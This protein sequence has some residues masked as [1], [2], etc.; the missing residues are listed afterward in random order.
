MSL[1][2]WRAECREEEERAESKRGGG[3]A[4]GDLENDRQLS[5]VYSANCYMYTAANIQSLLILD[6]DG[7]FQLSLSTDAD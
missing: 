6:D 1:S 4:E 5:L 3:S 7:I 2:G